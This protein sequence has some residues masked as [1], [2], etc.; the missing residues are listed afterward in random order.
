MENLKLLNQKLNE[1]SKEISISKSLSQ[2]LSTM[3]K[4]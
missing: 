1:D 4:V 3:Q 2:E